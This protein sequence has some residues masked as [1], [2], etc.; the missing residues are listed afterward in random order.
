MVFVSRPKLQTPPLSFAA[1]PPEHPGEPAHR[2]LFNFR[3][4]V[5]LKSA[6]SFPSLCLFDQKDLCFD[7]LLCDVNF[8]RFSSQMFFFLLSYWNMATRFPRWNCSYRAF[9]S[10]RNTDIEGEDERIIRL[11]PICPNFSAFIAN[12]ISFFICQ[13]YHSCYCNIFCFSLCFTSLIQ[14]HSTKITI[15]MSKW[16]QWVMINF[17]TNS[18][19]ILL[20]LLRSKIFFKCVYSKITPWLRFVLK[21]GRIGN[22]LKT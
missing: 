3:V 2:L 4:C 21:R 9:K 18:N 6:V 13:K 17:S 14:N 10:R 15:P 5:F 12:S 22:K 11:K 7:V 1:P 19:Y 8:S 16:Y 20:S